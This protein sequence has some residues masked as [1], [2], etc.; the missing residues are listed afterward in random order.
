[1]STPAMSPAMTPSMSPAY[2]PG[3]TMIGG[4]GGSS[5]GGQMIYPPTEEPD[6]DDDVAE[7]AES[8]GAEEA[9]SDVIKRFTMQN[10]FTP[11]NIPTIDGRLFDWAEAASTVQ[12]FVGGGSGA[13]ST[14]VA[15]TPSSLLTTSTDVTAAD[16]TLDTVA[17]WVT[18]FGVTAPVVH[19]VVATANL[20]VELDLKKIAM[21]AR[22]A[23]YNPRRF[24][25]VIMRIRE[26]K[27]T[28]LVFHSGKM[29]VTG[30]KSEADAKHAARKFGRVVVKVGY[31]DVRF[32][33]FRVE[34]LVSM[35][36]VPYPIPLEQLYKDIPSGTNSQ[37]EPEVFPG[38]ILRAPKGTCLIFVSG[39]CVMIG[40]KTKED[41]DATF[42]YAMRYLKKYRKK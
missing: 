29:V 13:V 8:D 11:Q 28:A 22:N 15:Q 6:D 40:M 36:T 20:G 10:P 31:P 17:D 3:T 2:T 5:S 30:T 41:I 37:Y 21:T 32:K 38:L 24:K 42:I 18:K 39:K 27:A 12:S 25:A 7:E 19:N 26:P 23:E 4:G 9:E 33:E 14:P 35:F 16:H 1:V 34:N